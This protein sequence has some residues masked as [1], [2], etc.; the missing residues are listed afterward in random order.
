MAVQACEPRTFSSTLS[1]CS[2][3]FS[4]RLP[5]PVPSLPFLAT[6]AVSLC[7]S[8]AGSRAPLEADA[9]GVAVACGT[10]VRVALGRF[11]RQ[12]A[13]DDDAGRAAVDAEGAA[14]AHVLVDDEGHVVARIVT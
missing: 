12:L 4:A 6:N 7:L 3:T 2:R 13:E 5:S 11:R 1:S 14:G 8:R 10:G 9:V